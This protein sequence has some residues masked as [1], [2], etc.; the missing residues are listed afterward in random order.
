[1]SDPKPGRESFVRPARPVL[2]EKQGLE[3]PGCGCCDLRVIY[4][5]KTFGGRLMRRRECRNCG[6]RVMTFERPAE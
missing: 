1:M 4:T 3:C 5:R 6:R 2:S